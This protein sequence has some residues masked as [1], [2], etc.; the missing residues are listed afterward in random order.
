MY[1]SRWSVLFN[2]PNWFTT[3]VHFSSTCN[4]CQVD[5]YGF[6]V[7]NDSKIHRQSY[8]H[9]MLK[10]FLHPSCPTCKIEFQQRKDWDAHK[11]SSEHLTNLTNDGVTEVSH[12]GWMPSKPFRYIILL[13]YQFLHHL[14]M[15]IIF[16]GSIWV[17]WTI[18]FW[19]IESKCNK[20]LGR[21]CIGS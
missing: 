11:F 12:L 20:Y 16:V 19:N 7:K 18:Y 6:N 14:V 15:V 1:H 8:A 13:L 17:L 5:V 10:E 21:Q 2:L 9:Q 4:M 3:F